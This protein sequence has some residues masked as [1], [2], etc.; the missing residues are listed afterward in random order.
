[1]DSCSKAAGGQNPGVRRDGWV[2]FWMLPRISALLDCVRLNVSFL[3]SRCMALPTSLEQSLQWSLILH[4]PSFTLI[5]LCLVSSK[6]L[7]EG[8][9]LTL[10]SFLLLP[11]VT[12]AVE[13]RSCRSQQSP[14]WPYV[15]AEWKGWGVHTAEEDGFSEETGENVGHLN[16]QFPA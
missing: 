2:G 9:L 16:H 6:D 11:L 8:L 1:M 13:G 5:R 7:K 4:L 15:R 3:H 10:L 14:P 12:V